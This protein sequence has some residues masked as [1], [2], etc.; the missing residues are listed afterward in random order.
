VFL[1]EGQFDHDKEFS[2]FM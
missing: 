2:R 1:A